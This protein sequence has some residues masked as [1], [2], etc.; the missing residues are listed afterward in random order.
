MRP[1]PKAD[2]GVATPRSALILLKWWLLNSI[3]HFVSATPAVFTANPQTFQADVIDRSK[4]VPVIVLFWAEQMPETLSMRQVLDTH[5]SSRGDKLSLALIDVA[6]DQA[7]AQ[8]LA[9]SLA[10]QSVPS[11]RVIRDGQLFDQLDGPQ[12]DDA[13]IALCDRLTLSSADVLKEQLAGCLESGNFE[14]ALT[15]LQRAIEEEPANAEFRVELADILAIQGDFDGARKALSGIDESTPNIARPRARLEFAEKVEGLDE[16]EVLE[17]KVAE[18]SGDLESQY[19]LS[20]RYVCANRLEDA[21]EIALDILC[22][23]RKFRD[24]IGRLTMLRI[25][26]LLPKGSELASSYRRRMFNFMH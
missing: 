15:L 21:L 26:E 6:A 19:G 2:P 22:A 24:D 3:E 25:F 11:I 8:S 23:D 10:V 7:F 14:S 5:V 16:M 4:E 9:Q 13:L 1:P 20:V 18:N 12:P 17:A